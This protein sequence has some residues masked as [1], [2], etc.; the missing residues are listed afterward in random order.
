MRSRK[1]ISILSAGLVIGALVTLALAKRPRSFANGS[2]GGQHIQMNVE[3]GSATI[4][5]DCANGKI[6]GP[7]KVDS[8]GRFSLLGMHVREHGGPIRLGEDRSGVPARY[9]GWTDGKTMKLTVTLTNSKTAV[10]TF[11]LT[12][13]SIGRIRKCR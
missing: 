6:N 9:T 10:G 4:E 11:E 8:R 7:L 12:R 1:L 3:N 5:Y 13:G 2:W